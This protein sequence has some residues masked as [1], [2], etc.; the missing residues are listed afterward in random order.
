VFCLLAVVALI[1][2]GFVQV[3]TGREARCWMAIVSADM[4]CSGRQKKPASAAVAK[5]N[6]EI[7]GKSR[8]DIVLLHPDAPL[9]IA[10]PNLPSLQSILA[11]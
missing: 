8:M 6:I 11:Q 10:V 7:T 3:V 9:A 1:F 5:L 4:V 2:D